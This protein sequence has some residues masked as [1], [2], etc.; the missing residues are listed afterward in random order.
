MIGTN[1]RFEDVGTISQTCLCANVQR[2]ARAIGRRFDDAFRP[3]D[4][5]NWQFTLMVALH[6]PQAPTISLVAH[7]LATDR[8]TITANLKPLERRGL[9]TVRPDGEDRRARRVALTASGLALLQEAY[10]VWLR[11]QRTI[12][13][14]LALK[15]MDGI[16]ASL[17]AIAAVPPEHRA[18]VDGR[19]ADADFHGSR[20][21]GVRR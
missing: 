12:V 8:T 11:A 20:E 7:D 18:P 10:V 5:T 14:D 3:L 1:L 15:D 4:L 16:L 2:A 13:A 9:V 19:D 17:R 6:R 21:V